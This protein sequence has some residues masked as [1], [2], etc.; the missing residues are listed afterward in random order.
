MSPEELTAAQSFRLNIIKKVTFP[1]SEVTESKQ[2]AAQS[3]SN[4]TIII[5][6]GGATVKIES[7]SKTGRQV[8]TDR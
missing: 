7:A 2:V 3:S 6:T 8:G 4:I 1:R 5:T